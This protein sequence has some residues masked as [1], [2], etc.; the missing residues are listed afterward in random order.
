[1]NG[2]SQAELLEEFTKNLCWDG[3]MSGVDTGE[4]T[5]GWGLGS[6]HLGWV[7]ERAFG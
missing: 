2:E 3:I 4:F 7:F 5:L 1:M 6:S